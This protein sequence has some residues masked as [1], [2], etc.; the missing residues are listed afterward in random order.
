MKKIIQICNF[1]KQ[2]WLFKGLINGWSKTLKYLLHAGTISSA[3]IIESFKQ[4]VYRVFPH[5]LK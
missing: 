1:T 4:D 3:Q 5:K 2:K